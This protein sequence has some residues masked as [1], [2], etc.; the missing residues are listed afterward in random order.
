MQLYYPY[1]YYW[2]KTLTS[3]RCSWPSV[4]TAKQRTLPPQLIS[5]RTTPGSL[6]SKTRIRESSQATMASEPAHVIAVALATGENRFWRAKVWQQSALTIWRGGGMFWSLKKWES[7][8][9]QIF[10][11]FRKKIVSYW[12]FKSVQSHQVEIFRRNASYSA[13]SK[14]FKI[15]SRN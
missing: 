1:L 11:K 7:K 5:L 6:R 13:K 8:I 3:S 9:S 14:N 15:I 4:L 12:Q 2:S 10:C